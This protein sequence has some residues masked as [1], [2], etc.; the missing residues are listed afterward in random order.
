MG[1]EPHVVILGAGFGGVD[2][3]KQLK[4]TPFKVTLKRIVVE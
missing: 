3:P 1:N 2:A 4:K